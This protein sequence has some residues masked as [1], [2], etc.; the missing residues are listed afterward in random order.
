LEGRS[1][2]EAARHLGIA[3]GTLS[4]RLARGR[5]LL[6]QRLAPYGLS[7]TGAALGAALC[8]SIA[9]AQVPA[10]LVLSTTKTALLVAAG[11]LAAV[12][13]SSAILM[14][15]VLKSMFLTKLKMMVGTVMV[16][17]AVGVSSGETKRRQ[18]QKRVGAPSP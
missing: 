2:K 8:E 10:A 15:G 14:K 1:R 17:T 11:E 7:L 5:R 16:V 6:A 12:S 4:S 13:A 9:S 18:T 3:E